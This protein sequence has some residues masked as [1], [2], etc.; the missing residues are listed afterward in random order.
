MNK[1][2][3][4]RITNVNFIMTLLIVLLHSNCYEYIENGS[5]IMNIIVN[6][7]LLICNIAVPTFF[8]ISSYLFFVNYDNNKYFS[9]LKKRFKSLVIPYLIWS[10]IFFIL[11]IVVSNLP[12][13]KMFDGSYIAIEYNLL[14]FLKSI[15][16]STYNGVMWFVQVL[17]FYILIS[18]IFYFLVKKLGNYNWIIIIVFAILN[19]C[20]NVDYV[21]ILYWIPI[22]YGSALLAVNHNKL[23]ENYKTDTKNKK[24]IKYSFIVLF[25]VLLILQLYFENTYFLIYIYKMLSPVFVYMMFIDIKFEKKYSLAK[26]SFLIF[27]SHRWFTIVIKKVLILIFGLSEITSIIFQLLTFVLTIITI[28][29]IIKI[30][31]KI[32]I[33]FLNIL[34]GYRILK[35]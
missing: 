27:C 30:L 6:V 12:A 23:I 5:T 3:S 22:Y 35:E 34:S 25:L 8:A 26:Y 29:L 14:F 32:S 28:L 1:E 24:I 9:K 31:E 33:K 4:K 2:F 13:F 16:F 21:S 18:P 20:I 17:L 10:S 7:I 19:I 15:L 11:F